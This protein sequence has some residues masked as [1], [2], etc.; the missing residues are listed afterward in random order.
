MVNTYFKYPSFKFSQAIEFM[1]F[2]VILKYLESFRINTAEFVKLTK[3]KRR[4]FKNFKNNLT[5]L[6][7]FKS[8]D[9]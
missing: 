2:R 8:P 7:K 9:F 3:Q 5:F 4:I 6:L 1:F